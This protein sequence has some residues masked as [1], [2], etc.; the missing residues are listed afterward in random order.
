L[1]IMFSKSWKKC[2]Q[3]KRSWRQRKLKVEHRISPLY[4]T[5][6]TWKRVF[7]RRERVSEWVSKWVASFLGFLSLWKVTLFRVRGH[8]ADLGTMRVWKAISDSW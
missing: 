4:C 3:K 8:L 6:G 1:P 7:D 5:L 2:L